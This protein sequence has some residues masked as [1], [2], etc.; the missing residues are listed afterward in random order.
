M[1]R[2]TF[3]YQNDP[4]L[5]I[6]ILSCSV[7]Y[8]RNVY[9]CHNVLNV[10]LLR[11]HYNVELPIWTSHQSAHLHFSPWTGHLK[12]GAQATCSFHLLRVNVNHLGSI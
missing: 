2:A 7:Y 8:D 6:Q 10:R 4:T 11:T 12:D 9:V 1:P 3:G 5:L